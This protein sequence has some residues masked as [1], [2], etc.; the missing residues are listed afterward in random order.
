MIKSVYKSVC[1][2]SS[3]NNDPNYK[4]AFESSGGFNIEFCHFL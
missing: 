2:I 3:A 4:E 1:L